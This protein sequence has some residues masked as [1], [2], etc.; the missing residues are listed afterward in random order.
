MA[1]SEQ[2][3]NLD[4]KTKGVKEATKKVSGLEKIV[5][6]LSGA[7]TKAFAAQNVVGFLKSAVQSSGALDKELLVLRLAL[8]KLKAAIGD[9]IAPLGAVFIPIVQNA[10]W[11]ATRLVKAVG[12]VIAALFGQGDAAKSTAGDQANLAKANEEV[13]R[14]LMGFDEINRLDASNS[15]QPAESATPTVNDTLS[16]QLQAVVDKILSLIAPLNAIDFTPAVA[17]FGRLKE[18]IAPIGQALFAGLEWVWFN[19][20]VPLAAWTIEDVLPVFLDILASSL[21][22]LNAVI[23]ALQPG[24]TWLWETFL[25][26]IAQWTGEIVI[27]ALQWLAD[28]LELVSDWIRNNQSMVEVFAL[29]LGSFAAAWGLVNTAVGVWNTISSVGT[30][31]TSAF[32]AAIKLFKSSTG[33]AVTAIG[34]LITIVV[35]LVKNWDTVKAVAIQVWE[36]IKTVWG[37]AWAWF[38]GKIIDPLVNGFKGMVNGIIG[39]LNAMIAGI[40]SGVNGIVNAVN[41]LSFTAP[42]WIPGIGGKTVGFNLKTVHT[43]QIPYLAQGAVLPANKPFLAVVGDQKHGTNVE[44]PLETIQQAVAMVMGEQTSALLA[45][46]ATSVEVQREILQ[47][48]LGIQIGDEVIGNAMTRYRQ[49]MA[50]VN[51]GLV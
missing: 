5:K 6:K 15:E 14:S 44:A 23:V 1:K 25:Q 10:V 17:A 2:T 28:K 20:L 26:P 9:A 37:N 48:V 35:L 12:K 39:F 30:T 42:D 8:G 18:A 46:F 32:G 13:K 21:G 31:V 47:A 51:G 27:Q 7:F 45:G 38:R 19:L 40:V 43:P 11:A 22:V 33:L 41:K 36:T 24:A 3:I 16:P 49:K 29:A 50:V 4:V 34:A